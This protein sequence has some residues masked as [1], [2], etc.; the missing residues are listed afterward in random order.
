MGGVSGTSN[1]YIIFGWELGLSIVLGADGSRNQIAGNT[2]GR[3]GGG[4]TGSRRHIQDKGRDIRI[5]TLLVS[6]LK[7]LGATQRRAHQ[8]LAEL[9][10]TSFLLLASLAFSSIGV[11]PASFA[12]K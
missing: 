1:G 9:T 11:N 7:A 5:A 10:S 4:V 8:R 12:H 3:C 2:H 6:S